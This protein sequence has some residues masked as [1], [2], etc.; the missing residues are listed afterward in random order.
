MLLRSTDTVSQS[1]TARILRK[2]LIP[3]KMKENNSPLIVVASSLTLQ[4]LC[5]SFVPSR[6]EQ[7][8][9]VSNTTSIEAK[10]S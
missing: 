1:L 10:N 3:E 4:V 7:P 2:C 8:L 9:E 5:M 6:K